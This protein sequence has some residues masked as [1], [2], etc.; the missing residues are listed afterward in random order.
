MFAK[1]VEDRDARIYFLIAQDIPYA[2]S[3]TLDVISP[4]SVSRI[5]P[6]RTRLKIV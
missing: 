2:S 3:K 5:S 4:N 1:D 6:N